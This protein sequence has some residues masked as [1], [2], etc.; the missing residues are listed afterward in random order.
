MCFLD[1]CTL[2]SGA[3]GSF[4]VLSAVGHAAG[5][6]VHHGGSLGPRRAPWRGLWAFKV[7]KSGK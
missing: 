7:T 5:P 6:P 3:H 4:F 2:F 1:I